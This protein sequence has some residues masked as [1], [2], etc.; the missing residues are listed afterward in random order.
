MITI[1]KV[2]KKQDKKEFINFQYEVYKDSEH[3]C[4]PLKMDREKLLDTEKNPF[5]KNNEMQLF[6]AYQDGKI[7]GRVAAIENV[8]HNRIHN[9]NSG[10]FGFYESIDSQD[11]ANELIKAATDWNKEKG[12]DELIGPVSPHL[13]DDSPGFLLVGHDDDN[14]MLLAYTHKYYLSLMENMGLK[15]VKDLYSY[16]I[17]IQDVQGED[18]IRRIYDK[19]AVR[20]NITIR[21]INMKNFKEDYLIIQEI[22]NTAWEKNW[23]QVPLNDEDF[24]YIASD[25]KSLVHT[26]F[27]QIAFQGDKPIGMCA[28]FPDVNQLFKPM[29][30]SLFSFGIFKF[31]KY[32]LTKKAGIDRL[33]VFIL[34]VLPEFEGTGAAAGLYVSLLDASKKNKIKSAEMA[35]ILEDNEKMNRAAVMLGANITKRY[36][37]FNKSI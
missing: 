25:L 32:M 22:F 12:Y 31:L 35:W 34:G 15:K 36:R 33:R 23:G 37:L 28:A 21:P 17:E 30:G 10:F 18:K 29:K 6:L 24:E 19:A 7:V 20:N 13:N 3:F 16:S 1:K 14:M 26:D 8:E 2:E 9:K 5:Y 11:V 4:P 27:M